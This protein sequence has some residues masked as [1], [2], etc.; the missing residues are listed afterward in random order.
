MTDA[1]IYQPNKSSAST[2]SIKDWCMKPDISASD[3]LTLIPGIGAKTAEGFES[4]GINTIAQ[5][6]GKFLS[7]IDGVGGTTEV[8]QGF[9][10]W[11]KET[12]KEH[13]FAKA[14]MHSVCFAMANWATVSLFNF[15]LDTFY[16]YFFCWPFFLFFL[17]LIF[18]APDTFCLLFLFLLF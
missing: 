17:I 14:N 13:G 4:A 2:D 11:C 3:S 18:N 9:F 6:L 16:I 7:F 5:L 1:S 10:T 15:L 12:A 8:C